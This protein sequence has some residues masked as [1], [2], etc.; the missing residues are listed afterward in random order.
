MIDELKI[1]GR[2]SGHGLIELLSLHFPGQ[3]EENNQNL[4]CLIVKHEPCFTSLLA[5]V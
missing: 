1:I 3:T 2:G 4:C 5:Q